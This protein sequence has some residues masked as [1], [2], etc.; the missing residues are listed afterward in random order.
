MLVGRVGS[1]HR[2]ELEELLRR[3]LRVPWTKAL[4]GTR[5]EIH[6]GPGGLRFYKG[7]EFSVRSYRKFISRTFCVDEE[8]NVE[9]YFS[10]MR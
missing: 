3:C 1:R 2:W 9:V 4:F 7:C 5:R 8:L 6:M 10:Q